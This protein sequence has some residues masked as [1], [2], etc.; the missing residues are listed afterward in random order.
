MLVAWCTLACSPPRARRLLRAQS[1][2]A[3]NPRHAPGWIAAARVEE[4]SKKLADARRIIAEGCK[5]CPDNEDVWLEAVRLAAAAHARDVLAEAVRACSAAAL[6]L[7]AQQC[8]RTPRVPGAV[9]VCVC[10]GGG[11]VRALPNSVKLWMRA[12]EMEDGAEGKRAVLRLA[13]ETIPNSVRLWKAAV[14]LEEPEDAKVRPT[15]GVHFRIH[16]AA[17][18]LARRCCSARQCSACPSPWTCGS[19]SRGS[20]RTCTRLAVVSFSQA[21]PPPPPCAACAPPG[22][23]MCLCMHVPPCA[24]LRVSGCAGR[25]ENARK[26]LNDARRKIPTE[27]Q[28]W[29]AAARLEEARGCARARHLD[30]A[31]CYARPPPP[32]RARAHVRPRRNMGA[33]DRIV[34]T[35]VASLKGNGARID[36]EEWQRFARECEAAGAVSTAAATVRA[37]GGGWCVCSRRAPPLVNGSR[38]PPLGARW[39]A[40]VYPRAARRCARRSGRVW[41]TSTASARGS[42]TRSSWSETARSTARAP[43]TCARVRWLSRVRACGECGRPLMRTAARGPRYAHM[44]SIG[45]FRGKKGVWLRAAALEKKHGSRDALEALL[46]SAVAACPQAEVLWLMAAKER[47][48]A[49]DVAASRAILQV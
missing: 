40:Y 39:C 3:T 1:V 33:A 18:A 24:A 44:T 5:H 14:E 29:L 19:R 6:D 10:G 9:C 49:G 23:R 12:A 13:L 37:A 48:L 21:P 2:T 47:W 15:A 28:I 43:C 38:A 30:I 7:C 35:A 32:P 20:N 27:P 45:A 22:T 46:R 17:A 34:N 41:R 31:F 26:V 4:K 16:A 8:T 11:Q 36:R 25:Y 42:A